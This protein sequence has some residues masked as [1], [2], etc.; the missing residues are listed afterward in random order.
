MADV[1]SRR[2]S[3]LVAVSN[4]VTRFER[5][6]NDYE[7][8][9]DFGEV[10]KRLADGLVREQDDYFLLDSYLFKANNCVSQGRQ[11]EILSFGKYTHA[12]CQATSEETRP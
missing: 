10:Y 8:C 6:K 4:E 1:L 5:I 3:I 12:K 9:P 2:V 7:Y 11:L